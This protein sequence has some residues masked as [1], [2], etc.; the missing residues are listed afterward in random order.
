MKGQA[1]NRRVWRERK[2]L[3]WHVLKIDLLYGEKRLFL[4]LCFSGCGWQRAAAV[5]QRMHFWCAFHREG[6]IPELGVELWS[7]LCA[8][9]CFKRKW[10]GVIWN[11]FSPSNTFPKWICGSVPG[12]LTVYMYWE[13]GRSRRI[14]QTENG[15]TYWL[16]V[17]IRNTFPK[18]L[19]PFKS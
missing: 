11:G 18:C 1:G 14:E 17:Y 8:R 15:N 2:E 10:A 7:V 3:V 19:K 12:P 13:I 6:F 5:L 9:C 16:S 4:L